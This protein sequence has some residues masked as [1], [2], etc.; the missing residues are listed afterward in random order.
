MV[1]VFSKSDKSL[2]SFMDKLRSKKQNKVQ[3]QQAASAIHLFYA[4]ETPTRLKNKSLVAHHRVS[5]DIKAEKP[6]DIGS[7][8][9]NTGRE[10][11]GHTF[12]HKSQSPD[13]KDQT[14]QSWRAEYQRLVDEIEVRHY[15]PKTLKSYRSWVRK[16][17]TFTRSKK[18]KSLD[19]HDV[20]RF[21]TYLAVEKK[22][23]ASSQNLAFNPL[24]FFF[25]KYLNA[26]KEFV[27]QWFFPTKSLTFVK[28]D[29]EYRRYH[30]HE[31]H[32]Q[33]AIKKAVTKAR[34]TKRASAH[35]LRHSYASHLLEA[36][37]DIRTIQKLLGHSDV[38]TTMIYTHM[39]KPRT[40][41]EAKGPLDL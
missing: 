15:S 13:Q 31:T 6:N 36:N 23:S 25:K 19:A 39:V 1:C 22:V 34:I 5:P 12:I 14:N 2:S 20:K 33:R 37:F 41:K 18:P 29:N 8:K 3:Q 32:V 27:W 11:K 21:L 16:F 7:G 28:E 17:Q 30:L 26:A 9:I 40:I 38:R 4:M 24:L 10:V 35:A